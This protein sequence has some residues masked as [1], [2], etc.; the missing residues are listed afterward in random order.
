MSRLS[1]V[2]LSPNQSHS[3][4]R[5]LLRQYL[6]SSNQLETP[7]RFRSSVTFLLSS[8]RGFRP[9]EGIHREIASA[10]KLKKSNVKAFD[11]NGGRA[12]SQTSIEGDK[13]SAAM[14]VWMAV[15]AC[16]CYAFSRAI[17]FYV[18]VRIGRRDT[19]NRFICMKTWSQNISPYCCRSHDV[20]L[21]KSKAILI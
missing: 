18:C 11:G 21:C 5:A 17:T 12:K 8:L 16:A 7:L 10:I 9:A 1:I 13:T 19:L 3:N 6:P 20:R 15:N 2:S 14:K 4:M